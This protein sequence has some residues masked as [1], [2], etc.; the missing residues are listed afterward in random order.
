MPQHCE[1]RY[2]II[3]QEE[4]NNELYLDIDPTEENCEL[5]VSGTILA[6]LDYQQMYEIGI[7]FASLALSRGEHIDKDSAG[8]LLDGYG[9]KVPEILKKAVED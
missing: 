1:Y 7:L 2:T 3:D 6:T 4:A 5:Q 9:I 8:E